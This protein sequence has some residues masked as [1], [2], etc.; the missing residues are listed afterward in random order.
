MEHPKIQGIVRLDDVTCCCLGFRAILLYGPQEI[1]WGFMSLGHCHHIVDFSKM[2]PP[3]HT[4]PN[5]HKLPKK[6]E[7]ST[8]LPTKE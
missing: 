5:S 6:R 7:E 2:V 8:S 4:Q 1:G 3:H